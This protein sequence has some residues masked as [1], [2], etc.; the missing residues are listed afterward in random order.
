MANHG[1]GNSKF[2]SVNLN[3]S[4]GQQ[5]RSGSLRD[6]G[7]SRVRSS[8]GG[9][10]GVSGGSG[11]VVLSR[12]RSSIVGGAFQKGGPKLLVPPPLNL[13]SL[14]KEH[15]KFDSSTLGRGGSAGSGRNRPYARIKGDDE[16]DFEDD[17]DVM[18]LEKLSAID[19]KL[20][21]KLALLD[22]TFGKKGRVLEE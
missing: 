21:D 7:G 22:H 6:L 9:G 13:P 17:K 10:N 15:E 16:G 5:Q 14:R 19:K 3:K 8:G 1:V 11:M 20:E 18:L 4:Y 2:V 12:S